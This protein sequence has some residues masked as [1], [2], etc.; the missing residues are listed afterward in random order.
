PEALLLCLLL[1]RE[2][3]DLPFP[4]SSSSSSASRQPA[5]KNP[6]EQIPQL[7]EDGHGNVLSVP[8][9]PA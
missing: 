2:S 3:S 5:F 8:F 1:I 4:G 6:R 9:S 7:I